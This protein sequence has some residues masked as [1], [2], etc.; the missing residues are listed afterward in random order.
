M[1]STLIDFPAY[2]AVVGGVIALPCNVT[3]PSY[4]DGVS[5]VLWYRDDTGNPIYSVD[6][7]TTHLDN[8]KHFSATEILGTRGVFNITYPMAYMRINPVKANDG[9][10]YRCRV[11]FRRARTVN[12]ILKLNVI[13]PVSK[14][15]VFDDAGNRISDI[16]GPFNED[17]SVNLTCDSEGGNP[18]PVV[19]WWRGSSIADESYFTTPKGLIRN[20]I[21]LPKLSRDDLMMVLTCQASNTNLTVPASQTIA[22]DLNLKPKEVRIITPAHNMSAGD[23]VEL[24][25]Q[26]SGSRPPAKIQ[27]WKGSTQVDSSGESAS[28]DGSVTTN[29]LAFVPSVDDNGKR[30]SCSATN[31]QFPDFQLQDNWTLNVL[32][33]PLLSLIL[34]ASIQHQEI[35]EGSDVYFECNIQANPAVSEI[36]WLYNEQPLSSES[37]AGIQV[38][39]NSLFI[40]R[41]GA[42]AHR[43]KY[44]CFAVNS[45]GR[46]ESEVVNLKVQC[47]SA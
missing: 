12:R 37:S 21:Q 17:S 41:I 32:Y 19:K 47:K 33:A 28:D 45:Q 40:R 15:V 9:G 26:S 24:V 5:L 8:A 23:R 27:W 39:N 46:G 29:F 14:V 10:E 36:G 16:A 44:Q 4:D 31:L 22:I 6:A 2:S 30:L 35:L 18:P 42:K 34:G 20:V 43:G 38:R 3:P 13:V 25:C 7:R 11:D 1:F